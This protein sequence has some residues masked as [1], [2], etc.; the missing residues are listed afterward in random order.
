L[1]VVVAGATGFVGRPLVAALKARGDTVRVLV[2]DPSRAPQGAQAFA[3]DGAKG[4][5]P[6]ESLAGA[7]ALVNLAGESVADKSWTPARVAR[8]RSS[9]IDAT[10]HLVEAMKDASPRPAAFVSSSA[11]GYYGT[12]PEKTLDES[13]PAGRDLLAEICRDWEQAATPAEALGVRVVLLRTGVVL[14]KNGGALAKMVTPFKLGVGGRLGSGKQWMSWISIDDE[15]GLILHAIDCA[16]VRGPMNAVAPAP[17]TNAEFTKTL[18]HV[19]HRP[20]L[21]PAPAFAIKLAFGS[22]ALILLEGQKVEPAVAK[23][24]A[25][26]FRHPTLESCLRANAL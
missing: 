26:A 15:I 18:G 1:I 13:A 19:L 3:W 6:A 14:G 17:V 7:T 23:R 11:V 5:P 9:R 24:T 4:K 16:E 10:T 8:L 20:T 21:L 22:R 12:D 2:R 25:Y